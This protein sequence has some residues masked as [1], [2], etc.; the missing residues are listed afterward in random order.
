MNYNEAIDYIHSVSWVFCKPGLERITELC[1]KLGNPQKDL[2]FIHIA[3]TNGKGSF[4]AML[5]SVLSKCGYNI[6]SFTSP[7]VLRFNERICVNGKQIEDDELAEITEYIRPIADSLKDKPTE[8]ELITA[9]SFEYFKR[10]KCDYVCLECGLGGRLDSTNVIDNPIL[11]V[12]T[13][14]S[15]DHTAILGN[16][17]S[18]IAAQ[19]AGIIKNGVPC[20]WCGNNAEALKVIKDTVQKHS[21]ELYTVSHNDVTVKSADLNG[22]LLDYKE[23]KEIFIPLLGNYQPYNAANVL[24]AVDILRKNGIRISDEALRKGL[25]ETV[26]HARFEKLSSSPLVI[27]DGGHNPEGIEAAVESIKTYFKDKKVC[28]I[29]GV[30]A[31]KDY[32]YI[33]R[34]ISEVSQTVFC[35]TPDNPRSLDSDKYAEVFLNYKTPAIACKSIEDAIE[36]AK[37]TNMPIVISGSLYMYADVVKCLN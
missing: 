33:A 25:K 2:K 7:F 19:K 6:G 29:T 10:K 1:D 32:N 26:W 3:G 27:F 30:M 17:I 12:I 8:F 24:C 28:F 18:E 35:I 15:L 22:T 31:D 37:E 5:S 11:S 13:G 34:K 20:L 9:I 16:T 23:H 14:I 4:C 36:K 21:C